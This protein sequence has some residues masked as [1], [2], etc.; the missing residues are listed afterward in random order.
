[1]TLIE[2]FEYHDDMVALSLKELSARKNVA[3][4]G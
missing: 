1:M 3:L 2:L 4:G